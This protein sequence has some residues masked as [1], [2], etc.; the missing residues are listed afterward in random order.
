L[1]GFT[2]TTDLRIRWDLRGVPEGVYDVAALN[3]PERVVLPAAFQ[4]EAPTPL[5]I[6]IEHQNS[7]ILRRNALATFAFSFRNTSNQDIPV[8]RARVLFPAGSSLRRLE[9]SPG[10]LS[11]SQRTPGLFAPLSGDLYLAP[12]PARGDT[13]GVVD[14]VGGTL[15]P[16]ESHTVTLGL[17]GL[18]TSPYSV[19]AM[20]HGER[21][22]E[23]VEREAALVESARRALLAHPDGA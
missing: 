15:A 23:A 22:Q 5:A 12:N 10:L 4:V 19:S 13:L 3:G 6:A 18:P 2:N 1:I 21:I 20:A 8:V 17:R 16:G 14:L 7:D 9:T 11:R